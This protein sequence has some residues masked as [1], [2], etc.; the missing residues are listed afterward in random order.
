MK[1]CPYCDTN[2]VLQVNQH[3]HY[4]YQCPSCKTMSLYAINEYYA[5]R[6]WDAMVEERKSCC[7]RNVVDGV[8]HV[9]VV[10]SC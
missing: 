5:G 7:L 2:P 1:K 4:Y 10:K 8:V 9:A 3:K 6:E